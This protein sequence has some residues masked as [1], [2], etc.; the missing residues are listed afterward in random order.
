MGKYKKGEHIISL[1]ELA[2]QEIVWFIDKP[3]NRA[4]FQNWQMRLL[5]NLIKGGYLFYAIRD[6]E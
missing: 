5:M 2:K 3:L 1:D 6:E 4:F